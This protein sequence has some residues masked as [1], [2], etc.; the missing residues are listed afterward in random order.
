M[1]NKEKIDKLQIAEKEL[2][3]LLS[4]K[5]KLAS[6]LILA[7]KNIDFLNQEKVKREAELTKATNALVLE[8]K[9]KEAILNALPANIALINQEGI[10]KSVNKAWLNYGNENGSKSNYE[11][12]GLNYF[13]ASENSTAPV[14]PSGEKIDTGIR[15]VLNGN[16]KQFSLEYPC[17]SP[18]EQRWFQVLVAPFIDKKVTGA[19]VM[20]IDITERIKIEQEVHKISRLYSFISAINQTI[21]HAKNEVEVFKKA[22][23]I[24]I[25]VGKFKAAWIRM[26]DS[27]Y[28][29]LNIINGFGILPEEKMRIITL[30]NDKNEPHLY[31]LNYDKSYICNNIIECIEL[32]TWKSYAKEKGF[33]SI[34]VLPIRKSGKIFCTL[35]LYATEI[36]FFNQVEIKI[37]EEVAGDISFA[38]DVFEKD[39]L[40][41]IAESNLQIIF[42]STSEGFILIDTNGWVKN[43]NSKADLAIFLNTELEI[44]IGDSI[45]DFVQPSRKGNYEGFI[46]KVVLGETIQ[47]DYSFERINGEIKWYN[48][49]LSP[50]YNKSFEIEGICITSADITQRKK[51]EEE[52]N[53]FFELSVDM[54][55]IAGDDGYFKRVNPSFEKALG[56]TPTEFCAKPFIEFVHP[57]DVAITIQEFKNV[58]KGI[59]SVSFIN[60]YQCKDGN[61]KWMEW[62]SEQIKKTIYCTS[63]DI[64]G[65]KKAAELLQQSE[66]NLQ[67]IIE[68]TDAIIY[69]LDLEFRYITFN[70]RLYN[71]QKKTYDLDIKIG[72][73]VFQFFE[74]I[75]PLEVDN[76]KERYS[77]ALKGKTVKFEKEFNIGGIYNYSSFAI[78]PI[79]KNNSIIGLSCFVYD[80]TK[81]KEEEKHK[82]RMTLDLVQRNRDLEQFT[83]IISHNLRSPTANII[84]FTENLLDETLS[85]QE[86]KE[87]LNGLSL[88]VAGLDS[89]IKDI[90]TILQV[91]QEINEKKEV[92]NFSK[93]VE[94]IKRSIG[95]LVDNQ[96]IIIKTDFSEVEEMYSLKG[97]IHSIF[98]NLITNSIKYRKPKEQAII[99]I[100][101]QKENE[102]IVLTFKDNGLGMDMK[103]KG[104]KVFGL[105]KRFHSHVEG[106]GMGLFMVKTQIES[107]G[108]KISISSELNKGTQFKI[109]VKN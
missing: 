19:V 70:K 83:F 26:V 90:N 13:T 96:D 104:D 22:C 64:T 1:N 91:K 67:A 29:D 34:M 18:D 76:W 82:E 71:F 74:K 52:L 5:E 58:A 51:A 30:E 101:S 47:Y 69:S 50:A 3:F 66:S 95:N 41:V 15:S 81:Q 39:R 62:S 106:K 94:D 28:T 98:Y 108:G 38:L 43:Y 48:F 56:Y 89:V 63:R 88:S 31:V 85:Q 12:I 40:R 45:Y 16:Q 77:T 57:D 53:M 42:D 23:R 59:N 86:Q 54:L 102:N 8:N 14:E 92:I 37:L 80:I 10:I 93:L 35:N 109:I 105:Y 84:G 61:Y 72:D 32:E 78:Y 100:K 25:E 20:H 55:G 11:T 36:D 6:Q 73:S 27:S 65:R 103:T 33:N 46:S 24:A 17:H 97:Y 79:R 99:E 75:E 87:F 7:Q 44:K 60:R 107:L 2:A 21:V 68:N 49:T 4:E 9:E